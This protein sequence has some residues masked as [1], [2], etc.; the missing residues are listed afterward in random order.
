MT[1]ETAK[2]VNALEAALRE[3]GT[4]QRAEQEKRYLK[5]E[6]VHVGVTVPELR[7]A[8]KATYAALRPAHPELIALVTAVWASEIY[9]RRL[10][11]VELLKAG[12]ASLGP[13][14]LPMIERLIR[15]AAMWAL[16]DPLSG[17]VAGR[18]VL[19]EA[20]S[21]ATLDR[22]AADPDFWVRRCALLALLAG[23]R[24]G[25]PDLDR[26][27]AYAD[28]ML[29]ETEF[30]VRKAIGWVAGELSKSQPAFVTSWAQGN[31][32]RMSGVTFREVVRRLPEPD[33]ERL[34]RLRAGRGR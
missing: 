34:T 24:S 32:S 17:D 26:F 19:R 10:A 14:D 33:A 29:G 21:A 6:L 22:W 8:V 5:S 30:F 3:L 31:L 12:L 18:I 11:A 23:I 4:P 7:K 28:A 2:A 20:A 15:E 25:H 9:E 16:V 1:P 27:T 13:Q